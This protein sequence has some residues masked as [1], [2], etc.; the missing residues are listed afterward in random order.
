MAKTSFKRPGA[1]PPAA[2]PTPAPAKVA[3][4][5]APRM[6]P[7]KQA[8]AKVVEPEP[9]PSTG[10]TQPETQLATR[11]NI[12]LDDILSAPVGSVL[13]Q[14]DAGDLDIPRL[15]L[16][17][18]LSPGVIAG[19]F[20]AGDWVLATGSLEEGEG[21][22]LWQ[23]GCAPIELTVLKFQKQ[24]MEQKAFGGETMGRI[25][26]TAEEAQAE[27]LVPFG[28]D[29]A[30][31]VAI[32]LAAVLIKDPGVDEPAFLHEYGD[33]KY[34]VAW[35]QLTGMAYKIIGHKIWNQS[36]G[37]RLKAGSHHGSFIVEARLEKG[38]KAPYW[39]PV[40][41]DGELHDTEF[42][43]FAEVCGG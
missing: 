9:P 34:A 30:G 37:G 43:A 25:F 38:V 13:G 20:T 17:Q 10:D 19:H 26:K 1:P 39:A 16:M 28:G 5:L 35:W 31:Y 15:K 33:D 22:I 4:K 7:P 3:P 24:F 41:K 32:G 18:P 14:M 42:I 6:A 36:R 8:E 12:Q 23:D 2:A 40:I 11:E 29:D 27:G 21:S